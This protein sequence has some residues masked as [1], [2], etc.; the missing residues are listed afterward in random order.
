MIASCG[1]PTQATHTQCAVSQASEFFQISNFDNLQLCSPFTHTNLQ[2]L[3][4]KTITPL[5]LVLLMYDKNAFGGQSP[6]GIFILCY[7]SLVI[8]LLLRKMATVKYIC[9]AHC[10][11]NF[12]KKHDRHPTT[13]P[14]ISMLTVC[15]IVSYYHLIVKNFYECLRPLSMKCMGLWPNQKHKLTF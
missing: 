5:K 6:G 2:H 13:K 11:K 9:T 14:M 7:T 8:G 10:R 3:F 12:C 15:S 4:G 1:Y